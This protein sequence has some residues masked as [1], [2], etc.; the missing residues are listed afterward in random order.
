MY[1]R[2]WNFLRRYF[3]EN[4]KQNRKE[5]SA[6]EVRDGQGRRHIGCQENDPFGPGFLRIVDHVGPPFGLAVRDPT[7]TARLQLL[8]NLPEHSPERARSGET[9]SEMP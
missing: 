8:K 6:E 9:F 4:W 7:R 2:P 1:G 3:V 5:G